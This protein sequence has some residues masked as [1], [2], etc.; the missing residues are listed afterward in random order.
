MRLLYNHYIR[1]NIFLDFLYCPTDQLWEQRYTVLMSV[2]LQCI[3]FGKMSFFSYYL[4]Q[5]SVIAKAQ[6]LCIMI[7][8][9]D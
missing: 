6:S 4:I 9:L 8:L 3:T 1:L 7:P 2:S 5:Q